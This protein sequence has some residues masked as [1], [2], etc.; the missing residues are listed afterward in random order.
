[1]LGTYVLMY[2]V[3]L[4]LPLEVRRIT[5]PGV[6]GTMGIAVLFAVSGLLTIAG[7]VRITAWCRH[8]WGRGRCLTTGLALMGAACLPAL[9]VPV[10]AAEDGGMLRTALAI[11]PLVLAA[12]LLSLGTILLG[13]LLTGAAL[14]LAHA[15]QFISEH[16]KQRNVVERCINKA[17]RIPRRSHP[18]RQ[19]EYAY[20]GHHRRRLDRDLAPGPRPM[21]H[22]T[23]PRTAARVRRT[24]TS[25]TA[26][27]REL[28]ATQR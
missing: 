20:Q 26:R 4:A 19:R 12:A 13:N 3:Y 18:L 16:Y 6:A 5:G 25:L 7:Q 9:A 15:T 22:S 24:V 27:V 23:R 10:L 11:A 8:H 2:Q 14:D 17:H 21:I 28:P 1:M